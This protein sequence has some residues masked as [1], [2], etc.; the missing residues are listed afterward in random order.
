MPDKKD[1]GYFDDAAAFWRW[2]IDRHDQKD[3]EERPFAGDDFSDEMPSDFD[4]EPD[5]FGD[6]SDVLLMSREEAQIA[7][8][9]ELATQAYTVNEISDA[10]NYC[11]DAPPGILKMLVLPDGE[12]EI[13]R[14]PS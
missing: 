4:F 10:I 12:I 11:R 6:L 13:Y 2:I 1:D 8:D 9:S 3:N 14:F 7:T 5:D